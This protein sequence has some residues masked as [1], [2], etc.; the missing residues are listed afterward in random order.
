MT[1][2]PFFTDRI[3]RIPP[4]A[5]V[6]TVGSA[7]SGKTT[8]ARRQFPTEHILSLD[9][10]RRMVAGSETEYEVTAEAFELL[11]TALEGRARRRITTLVDGTFVHPQLRARILEVARAFGRTAI[12]VCFRV[13]AELAQ[14]R[15]RSGNRMIGT[16]LLKKQ[17]AL[18][19]EFAAGY[20]AE[21]WDQ[22]VFFGDVDVDMLPAVR[23]TLP[24]ALPQPGPFDVIGDV[25]GCLTELDRLLDLLGYGAPLADHTR[26]HPA[27]RIAVFVGD[28][29]DRGPDSPGVFRRV[30][31][32]HRAGSA[33][34]VPGNHCA[35][36][37]RYLNQRP[38]EISH[39]LGLTIEQLDAAGDALKAEVKRFL[40]G[41]PQQIVVA[42]GRLVVFH[43]ALPRDRVGHVDQATWAQTTYGVVRGMDEN[44]YPIRDLNWTRS[45]VVGEDEPL[46]IYGHT[47]V[48]APLRSYNTV[49]IDGGCVFG[50]YLAAY[51]WPERTMAYVGAE[52]VYFDS[53]K[54]NWKGPPAG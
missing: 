5:I 48:R 28:Y 3:L 29:A 18:V 46:A 41:L 23:Y 47:P 19:D 34:C 16:R 36:L 49:D 9:D 39:G 30:I 53:P 31:A 45:W 37:L 2:P 14:F 32:M 54:V 1:E 20:A 8:W 24:E 15:N 7:G 6:V 17:A 38:V 44:G 22:V 52:R 50:G 11:L 43:A 35:K 26:L 51:R 21:G 10:C 4:G 13:P 25:H 33:L 42:G 12:A 27:G 40:E